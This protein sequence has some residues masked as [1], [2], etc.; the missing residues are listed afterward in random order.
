MFDLFA[1][2]PILAWLLLPLIYTACERELPRRKKKLVI[3]GNP[4]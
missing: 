1:F 3:K 2:L 4:L